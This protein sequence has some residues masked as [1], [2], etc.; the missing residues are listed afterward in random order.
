MMRVMTH[1]IHRPITDAESVSILN[2]YNEGRS[3]SEIAKQHD[4]TNTIIR[5]HVLSKGGVSRGRTYARLLSPEQEQRLVNYY[6]EGA[7]QE[8]CTIKFNVSQGLVQLT[9][10]RY[11]VVARP[12]GGRGHKRA[13]KIVD[14][15]IRCSYCSR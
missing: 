14:D 11:G 3:F 13:K 1:R 8:E 5:R 9:L 6:N 12:T 7:S 10:K 15:K 2:A 4:R